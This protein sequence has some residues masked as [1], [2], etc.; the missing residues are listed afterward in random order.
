MRRKYVNIDI[1]LKLQWLTGYIHRIKNP[2]VV[3]QQ[4]TSETN[5]DTSRTSTAHT[6]S[7]TDSA[8]AKQA[9][10]ANTAVVTAMPAVPAVTAVTAVPTATN[11]RL[12][13]I[14]TES[15]SQVNGSKATENVHDRVSENAT[16]YDAL[17]MNVKKGVPGSNDSGMAF[18]GSSS[19]INLLFEAQE[20]GDSF[21]YKLP[22]D[23]RKV[24]KL[25]DLDNEE[26]EILKL[27]G[28][29][30]LPSRD[31]CDDI[32]ESYFEKIHPILPIL[33]RSQF[34]RRYNDTNNPPSLLLLQAMLLAG[35]RVSQNPALLDSHGSSDLASFTFYKRAKALFD[36]N[37][38]SDHITI[39][40]S[41]ILL[42]WWWEGPEDVTKNSFYWS[43]VA[44]SIA[45]GFGLHRSVENSDLP[46]ST[47]RTWKKIWWSLF[48]RDRWSAIALGRPVLINLEDSDVLMVTEDDFLEDEPG[49][50][51][52]YPINRIHVLVFI[53]SVKL[54]EIMGMVLRQQFSINAEISRRQNK[55]SVVS[56]CDMA[57]GSWMS[58]L[59][60]ELKYSVKD[61]SNH[62]F[63]VAT[64]HAQYYTVLC[65][66]HRSNVL[67]KTSNQSDHPYPSW[68][69]AF[70]AAHMISRI[71]ENIL[72]YEEVSECSAFY[73]YTIFSASIML[74]YQTE[75][76]T[77]SVVESA[78]RAFEICMQVLDKL[79]VRWTVAR[80]IYKMF[81]QLNSNKMLRSQFVKDAKK[82]AYAGV[83]LCKDS[84]AA[85]RQAVEKERT[86]VDDKSETSNSLQSKDI[87][88]TSSFK[89]PSV[90]SSVLDSV[91]SKLSFGETSGIPSIR[92]PQAWKKTNSNLGNTSGPGNVIDREFSFITNKPP[93]SQN[94]YQN[95]QP[96]QLFPEPNDGEVKSNLSDILTISPGAIFGDNIGSANSSTG[97]Q[98]PTSATH[99]QNPMLN[100]IMSA[101]SPVF[102][103]NDPISHAIPSPNSNIVRNDP[104]QMIPNTLNPNDWYQYLTL[105]SQ[106]AQVDSLANNSYAGSPGII[107]DLFN[108]QQTLASQDLSATNDDLTTNT[109]KSPK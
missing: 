42:G 31:L 10:T 75:S 68:G 71:F 63:F 105:A 103:I 35:S 72:L 33:N 76:P 64:L 104:S 44:L 54:S 41:V 19:N 16:T 61:K 67:R 24:S 98:T 91:P 26:I 108:F 106:N 80:V 4:A 102:P 50:P 1:G 57:M 2:A 82:R 37:Y 88:G 96:S 95:F 69:I 34:M 77:P 7:F 47:K 90:K 74:L 43:R 28:A 60:P 81:K 46:L 13:S 99:P 52:L 58:N 85:K 73:V 22:E 62:N 59:P 25:H 45:Q 79:S 17:N 107:N 20:E 89:S 83:D 78:K 32:I 49:L 11:L 23:F 18:L 29:F 65:L 36:A 6:S 66:V 100:P 55:I 109:G 12:N 84:S 94:F 97:G 40:Q 39:V 48:L 3:K 93:N 21:H 5:E 38:E 87:Q 92:P 9:N 14:S 101:H 27:R 51:A 56:H 86:K 30:L 15:T 70:Q 53:H 8:T